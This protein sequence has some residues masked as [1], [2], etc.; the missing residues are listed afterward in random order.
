MTARSYPSCTAIPAGSE[1]V[2][3]LRISLLRVLGVVSGDLLWLWLILSLTQIPKKACSSRA[4][5]IRGMLATIVPFVAIRAGL[6]HS[7]VWLR[8]ETWKKM[9]RNVGTH[10][11]TLW[12]GES[13][14]PVTSLASQLGLTGVLEP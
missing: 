14:A 6:R 10:P 5:E 8:K 7:K 1:C 12:T 9:G 2:L 11:G 3:N 4:Q 13:E